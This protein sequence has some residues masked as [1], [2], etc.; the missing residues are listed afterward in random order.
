MYSLILS[1]PFHFSKLL[2]NQKAKV[3]ELKKK[4]LRQSA[5]DILVPDDCYTSI[6][7]GV[8]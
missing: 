2:I 3:V 8:F 7:D 4:R 5:L 1:N 6:V